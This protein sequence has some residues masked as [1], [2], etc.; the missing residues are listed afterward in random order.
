M[1]S[2][3]RR[4]RNWCFT[5]N[6]Y[7]EK[8]YEEVLGQKCKYIV[9]GKEIGESGTAHLQGYVEYENGKTLS[10]LKQIDKRIHW[11]PRF[12][13]Q[14]QAA[15]Y[16]KK[17][18]LYEERG[19]ANAQGHRTD[20]DE[21][22]SEIESGTWKPSNN[23]IMFIKF[24][25]GLTEYENS[26][27]TD[28]KEKPVVEWRWGLTGTGKTYGVIERHGIDNCYIKDGTMWWNNYRQQQVIVIDDFDGKW[29]YRD[30]LR[31][32]DCYPYQGQYKGGYIKINSPYIYITCEHHPS[33]FWVGNELA[34]VERRI[35]TITHCRSSS[36]S[37][38]TEVGGNTNTPTLSTSG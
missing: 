28:R 32:L 2:S 19:S 14:Q 11:E 34:Q 31:L 4:Y 33:E 3:N 7:T 9:I 21:V 13:T 1:A 36:T 24:H 26:L 10:A 37:R 38:C 30:L 29:P 15:D 12:G 20:L 6:N 27:Y 35:N 5:L 23:P 16:C 17:T 25:R 8:D 22:V 18:G